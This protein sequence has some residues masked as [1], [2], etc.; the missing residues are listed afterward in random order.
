VRLGWIVAPV[1]SELSWLLEG[2]GGFAGLNG[3][4]ITRLLESGAY[5]RHVQ[6]CRREYRRRRDALVTTLSEHLPQLHVAGEAGG[7]HLTAQLPFAA[8]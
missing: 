6:R 2:G 7:L 4:V 3:T 1:T 8:G 5:E